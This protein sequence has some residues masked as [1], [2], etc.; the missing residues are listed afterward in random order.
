MLSG[1]QNAQDLEAHVNIRLGVMVT[2][3]KAVKSA[4]AFTGVDPNAARAAAAV[5][6]DLATPGCRVRNHKDPKKHPMVFPQPSS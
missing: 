4:P 2:C 3:K 5:T 1:F 6:K